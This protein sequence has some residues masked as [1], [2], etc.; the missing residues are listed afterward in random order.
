MTMHFIT[1]NVYELL[2]AAAQLGTPNEERFAEFVATRS[3]IRKAG[4]P[5]VEG[6]KRRPRCSSRIR[7]QALSERVVGPFPP[8]WKLN[9]D[10]N[11]SGCDEGS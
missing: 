9:T 5:G 8:S 11:E 7:Q 10:G 1:K 2:R 3:S 6:C 4:L